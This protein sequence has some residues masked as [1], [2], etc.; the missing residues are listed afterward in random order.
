M[1]AHQGSPVKACCHSLEVAMSAGCFPL[2]L[3]QRS[4]EYRLM[5]TKE[6]GACYCIVS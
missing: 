3:D 5:A 2:R 4:D 1:T 6:G